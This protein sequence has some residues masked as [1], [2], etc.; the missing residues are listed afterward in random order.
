MVELGRFLGLWALLPIFAFQAAKTTH[1]WYSL[2]SYVP[3]SI[4]AAWM[5]SSAIHRVAAAH[6]PSRRRLASAMLA[7]AVAVAVAAKTPL[8]VLAGTGPRDPAASSRRDEIRS[9]LAAL[10]S[11]G[12]APLVLFDSESFLPAL[13]FYLERANVEQRTERVPVPPGDAARPTFVVAESSRA[14]QVERALGSGA[15]LVARAPTMGWVMYRV[16]GRAA[17]SPRTRPGVT[18]SAG[19]AAPAIP[20]RTSR[21][22]AGSP[23]RASTSASE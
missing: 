12:G 5:V 18:P 22:R 23:S 3:L 14:A 21:P 8:R 11:S 16:H 17:G 19:R 6:F 4:L 10:G 15:T 2:P 1:P 20:A 13:G 9:A 7:L